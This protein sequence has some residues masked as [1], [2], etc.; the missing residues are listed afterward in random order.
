MAKRKSQPTAQSTPIIRHPLFPAVVA[1]WFGALFGLGSLA[2][3]P[4]LIEMLVLK[5]HIDTLIPTA[6]PPLGVTA[7]I[8]IALALAVLGGLLGAKFAQFVARPKPDAHQRKR[9]A[10]SIGETGQRRRD[11]H[12][13]APARAPISAHEELGENGLDAQ[14]SPSLLPGRRRALTADE[15]EAKFTVPEFAPLPGGQPQVID[16]GEL[17]LTGSEVE[18]LETLSQFDSVGAGPAAQDFSAQG[19]VAENRQVF[20]QPP[21][22]AHPFAPEPLTATVPARAPEPPQPILNYGAPVAPP[23][24]FSR[25]GDVV[26]AANAAR[27]ELEPLFQRA[28]NPVALPEPVP[29]ASQI[30]AE[31]VAE[32]AAVA[33][34]SLGL[35][36]LTERFAATLRKRR[37]ALAASAA[38]V[39]VQP[40]VAPSVEI[41]ESQEPANFSVPQFEVPPFAVP[42]AAPEVASELAF[43]ADPAPLTFAPLGAGD[44]IQAGVL[45][46]PELPVAPMAMPAALRPISFDELDEDEDFATYLP[47]RHIPMPQVQPAAGVSVEPEELSAPPESVVPFSAPVPQAYEPD[48]AP[49]AGEPTTAAFSLP[50][51]AIEAVEEPV[52]DGYSSLLD[53]AKLDETPRQTFV[54]IEEPEPEHAAIEPVVIFPGQAA[55]QNFA[56]LSAFAPQVQVQP[57]PPMDLAQAPAPVADAA[58]LRRFDAPSNAIAGQ[59]VAAQ[60]PAAVQDPVETERALRAALATLQRMSGAA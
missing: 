27:T 28:A 15:T 45:P 2:I 33:L 42:E 56:Q 47:L 5:T 23:I 13:D 57:A 52:A 51:D 17:D 34:D 18:A 29:A 60:A 40:L 39:E 4:G 48:S 7:R 24:D 58:T 50:V 38:A 25:P 43:A 35:V 32:A 30:T 44:T 12:P 14:T 59:Q 19:N 37:A 49:F 16:L 54:R 1:L 55:R 53:I 11:A 26:A 41:S 46:E 9:G 3:R 8:C 31:A 20:G 22:S 21:A 10:G 6:A 36:E